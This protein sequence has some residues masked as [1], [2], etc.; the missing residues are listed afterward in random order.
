[1]IILK[2]KSILWKNAPHREV[3]HNIINNTIIVNEHIF[4]WDH[5][6]EV[7]EIVN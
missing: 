5:F 2:V 6:F 1:M 4:S 3:T 7:N